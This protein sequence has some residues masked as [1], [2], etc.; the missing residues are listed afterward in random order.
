MRYWSPDHKA[1]FT[2][3]GES[4]LAANNVKTRS[5][6][7]AERIAK[8]LRNRPEA[9]VRK[10]RDESRPGRLDSPRHGCVFLRSAQAAEWSVLL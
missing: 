8:R 7:A 3:A 9:V 1:G 10:G 6:Q 5:A 2:V 4:E